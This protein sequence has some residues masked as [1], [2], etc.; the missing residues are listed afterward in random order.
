MIKLQLLHLFF[1]SDYKLK[2]SKTEENNTGNKYIYPAYL[3]RIKKLLNSIPSIRS[4]IGLSP[5]P[6][7][8][9]FFEVV[10]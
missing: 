6:H 3:L 7:V 10:K 1:L 2:C 8:L 9:S 4:A 5:F